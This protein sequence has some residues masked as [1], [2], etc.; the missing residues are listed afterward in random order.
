MVVGWTKVVTMNMGG[1]ITVWIY[2]Q[3]EL[4]GFVDKWNVGSERNRGVEN[5]ARLWS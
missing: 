5:E 2:F 3:E 1:G 4:T